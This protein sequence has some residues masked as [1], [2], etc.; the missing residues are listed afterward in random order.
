MVICVCLAAFMYVQNITEG[1]TKY[2]ND[3]AIAQC[4]YY[5]MFYYILYGAVMRLLHIVT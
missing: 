5:S 4:P 2:I 3:H 1:D